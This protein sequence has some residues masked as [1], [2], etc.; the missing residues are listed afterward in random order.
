[1]PTRPA[2]GTI[3]HNIFVPPHGALGWAGRRF[4]VRAG[5]YG[6]AY[7]PVRRG[8]RR[9]FLGFGRGYGARVWWGSVPCRG[10]S[11]GGDKCGSAFRLPVQS[12]PLAG[13]PHHVPSHPVANLRPAPTVVGKRPARRG[14]TS[15]R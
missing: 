8:W 14:G 6:A 12:P 5:G 4:Q 9:V 13:T 11:S 2:S 3:A 1:M 10:V 7:G 15:Q